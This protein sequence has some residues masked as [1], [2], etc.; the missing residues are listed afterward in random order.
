[1]LLYYVHLQGDHKICITLLGQLILIFKRIIIL[2]LSNRIINQP[3]FGI[4]ICN[5]FIFRAS[6]A[7]LILNLSNSHITNEL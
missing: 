3:N 5:S 6:Q 4:L 7:N 1:M 2:N